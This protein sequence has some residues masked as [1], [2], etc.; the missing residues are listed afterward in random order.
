MA[1]LSI[2]LARRSSLG[3]TSL[4][5]LPLKGA[6]GCVLGR[7][8][9]SRDFEEPGVLKAIETNSEVVEGLGPDAQVDQLVVA[10]LEVVQDGFGQSLGEGGE[11]ADCF[12]RRR[13]WDC[14]L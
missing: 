7:G 5:F 11:A 10:A 8:D 4:P 12:W 13:R 6:L 2:P 3:R 9:L 14:C 1:N